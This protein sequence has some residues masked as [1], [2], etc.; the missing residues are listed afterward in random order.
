MAMRKTLDELG[1]KHNCDKSSLSRGRKILSRKSPGH[2]Y[3]RKY[4][5]FLEKFRE[6]PDLKLLELGIGP[7]WNMGASLK[8]WL[9]FFHRD[10]FRIKMVDINQN[11]TKFEGERV[12]VSIG[13]LGD[14]SYVQSLSEDQF[15]IIIDDASHMWDHQILAIKTLFSSVAAGGVFIME[16]IHTSFGNLRESFGSSDRIDTFEF[17][18][19]LTTLLAGKQKEHPIQNSLKKELVLTDLVKEIESITFIEQSCIICKAKFY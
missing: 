2:D 12:N 16:D 8:V 18:V 7:D 6:K 11:A 5:F 1:I 10:D 13:D 14:E 4:A 9:D 3:L 19:S 17:L 15:D